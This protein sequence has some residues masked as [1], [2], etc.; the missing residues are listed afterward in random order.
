MKLEDVMIE[1]LART[2]LSKQP[3]VR[4]PPYLECALFLLT[5][6]VGRLQFCV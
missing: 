4:I 2:T 6:H 1:M 5:T 3:T